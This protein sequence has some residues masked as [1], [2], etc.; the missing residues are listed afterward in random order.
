MRNQWI[1]RKMS[2]RSICLALML[3]TLLSLPRCSAERP[4]IHVED[5]RDY[6][7]TL[8][9][10]AYRGRESGTAYAREAAAFIARRY[11]RAALFPAFANEAG[12]ENSYYQKFAFQGGI[13]IEAGS[14]LRFV[15]EAPKPFQSPKSVIPLPLGYAGAAK[16]ELIFLGFCLEAKAWNDFAGIAAKDLEGK[17]AL[18]LRHG[19]GGEKDPRF[20]REISFRAKYENLVKRKLAGVVFMGR[21]GFPAPSPSDLGGVGSR[22]TPAVFVEAPEIFRNFEFL[23]AAETR[24]REEDA[25]DPGDEVGIGRA[26]ATVEMATRFSE[27]KL[28]GYNVGAY[29]RPPNQGERVIVVGAHFDHIG[30]GSFS[31]LRGQGEIHNGADDNASG[32]AAVLEL[33]LQLKA[34]DAAD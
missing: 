5:L 23:R 2:A 28:D 14:Y 4:E 26:L 24:M 25:R 21:E 6:V 13:E 18:C 16:G 33:A 19:P 30:D 20:R 8:S 29:L 11:Q 12:G 7:T 9:A 32:T 3:G 34:L 15:D 17:V 31:S 1:E 22:S 10:D 27:R